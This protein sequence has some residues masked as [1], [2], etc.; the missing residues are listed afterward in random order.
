MLSYFACG[1]YTGR[2]D[3]RPSCGAVQT[4][5]K[6]AGPLWAQAGDGTIVCTEAR[7]DGHETT[8]LGQDTETP[9]T[10]LDNTATGGGGERRLGHKEHARDAGRERGG[11]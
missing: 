11:R 6:G 2:L 3:A 10:L 5:R 7:P 4:L 9:V 8:D 1:Q